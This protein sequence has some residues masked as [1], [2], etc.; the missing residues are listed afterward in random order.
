MPLE[1]LGMA[2]L[3]KLATPL[4][5]VSTLPV[6]DSVVVLVPEV[7]DPL[8]VPDTVALGT[9]DAPYFRVT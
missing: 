8:Q 4:L 1:V 6:P 9:V 5:L 7:N 2:G 3:L